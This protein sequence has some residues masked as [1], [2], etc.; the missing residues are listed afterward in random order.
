MGRTNN[1]QDIDIKNWTY[2]WLFNPVYKWFD[3]GS[4]R[5]HFFQPFLCYSKNCL[6]L[7]FPFYLF[8]HLH[9]AKHRLEICHMIFLLFINY[10]WYC[11]SLWNEIKCLNTQENSFQKS[12]FSAHLASWTWGFSPVRY[13]YFSKKKIETFFS[14]RV[15]FLI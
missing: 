6:G 9:E 10:F 8:H 15:H 1:I 2:F 13:P 14:N 3:N 11:S 12:Y 7:L 4:N 5:Y